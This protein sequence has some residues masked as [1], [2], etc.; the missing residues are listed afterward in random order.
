MTDIRLQIATLEAHSYLPRATAPSNGILDVPQWRSLSLTSSTGRACDDHAAYEGPIQNCDK[1]TEIGCSIHWF[2][3]MHTT[4][5]PVT[6]CRLFKLEAGGVI[7]SHVDNNLS[8]YSLARLIVPVIAD[9]HCETIVNDECVI[10]LPGECWFLNDD[11]YH[12][13][14]NNSHKDRIVICIQT[15]NLP[16]VTSL[17]CN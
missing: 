5:R 16:L 3:Q 8:R 10:M 12:S 9:R 6:R 11:H 17:I 7:P 14:R 13:I 1:L 2:A 15:Y 4:F